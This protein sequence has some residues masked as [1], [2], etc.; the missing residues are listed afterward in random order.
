M[1]SKRLNADLVRTV[2]EVRATNRSAFVEQK[3]LLREPD[4]TFVSSYENA[5]LTLTCQVESQ[6]AN[7]RVVWYYHELDTDGRMR[8][9]V[10]ISS[11]PTTTISTSPDTAKLTVVYSSLTLTNLTSNHSGYYSC[12]SSALLVDSLNRTQALDVNATYFLLV[13]C[14]CVGG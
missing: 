10:I 6:P 14:K 4:A 1:E 7:D 13:Q 2:A 12:S 11:T 5:S 9:R 8:N 3:N